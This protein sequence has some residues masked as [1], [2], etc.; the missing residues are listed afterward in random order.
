MA[1]IKTVSILIPAY[2]EEAT[3]GKIVAKVKDVDLGE[4]AKEIIVIDNNSTDATRSIAES[5]PEIRVCFEL[6]P[7]KGAALKRGIAEATGDVVIFQDADL[8]Y[9]PED[10]PALLQPLLTGRAEGVLGVRI[11]G[12]H[13]NLYI[14]YAGWLANTTITLLTNLLYRHNA[15][16]YEGCYKAFPLQLIRSVEIKTNNFDF[17]NELVCKLLKRKISLVDVPIH[18]YP[19]DFSEGKKIKAK[20][21]FLIL[22]TILKYRFID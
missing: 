4:I 16:E 8:E 10:Y 15:G 21:F 13:P 20:H 2:N 18:Y 1:L 3:I 12:R 17:D 14:R 7:G 9:E 6:A 11:E 5:I 19:R 22:W